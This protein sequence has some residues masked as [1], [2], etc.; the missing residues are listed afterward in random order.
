MAEGGARAT[1]YTSCFSE[2]SRRG[3]AAQ[4]RLI[5][6]WD[7]AVKEQYCEIMGVTHS[8]LYEKYG[9]VRTGCAC[10]PFGSR[11]ETE[12]TMAEWIDPNLAVAA[13]NIFGKAYEYTRAYRQFKAAHDAAAKSN[14]DQYSLF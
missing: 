2:P 6:F 11:F 8:D 4:F 12:L 7:D 10:C 1:A 14:P 3:D 9:F 13:K 5:F